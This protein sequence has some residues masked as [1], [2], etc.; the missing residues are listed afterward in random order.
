[1]ADDKKKRGSWMGH[2]L[3]A[4]EHEHDLHLAA[5][6]H[7]FEGG[8]PRH[9]AE[10]RALE[11][12][13]REHHAR[14]AA[15]HYA[16][17]K[18]G[19]ATGN[20][21]D[22]KK[23]HAL[24]S[25]HV[26]ALGEDP[27]G[28]VPEVV[29]KYHGGSGTD[30]QPHVYRFHGHDADEYLGQPITKHELDLLPELKKAANKPEVIA[31]LQAA[32]QKVAGW[33]DLSGYFNELVKGD[34]VDLHSRQTIAPVQRQ[35]PDWVPAGPTCDNEQC[36]GGNDRYAAERAPGYSLCPDCINKLHRANGQPPYDPQEYA[37]RGYASADEMMRARVGSVFEQGAQLFAQDQAAKPKPRHLSIVKSEDPVK[38]AARKVSESLKAIELAA[39]AIELLKK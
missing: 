3:L 24:Y 18:A 13:R 8:M 25:L 10:K 21:E 17:M 31:A 37:K 16:G 22:A 6:L 30:K 20:M 35:A 2:P 7:E 27:M 33:C 11:D 32:T 15:H 14:A 36:E 29:R 39:R 38:V 4:P 34:V 26:K 1:M 9:D 5:A 23:H 28:P 12:Y 19:H